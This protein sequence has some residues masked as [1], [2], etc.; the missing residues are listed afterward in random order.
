MNKL[1]SDRFIISHN[2]IRCTHAFSVN[3]YTDMNLSGKW[4][5]FCQ[6][7]AVCAITM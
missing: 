7:L 2:I 4:Q 3:L 1:A 6:I 5:I